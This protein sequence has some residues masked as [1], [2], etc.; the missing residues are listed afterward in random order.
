MRWAGHL[1]YMEM[2]RCAYRI[3]VGKYD[4]RCQMEDPGTDGRIFKQQ[5]EEGHGLG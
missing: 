2:R 3:L 5:V 4:V 1:A